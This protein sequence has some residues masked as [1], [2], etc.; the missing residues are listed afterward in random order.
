VPAPDLTVA[1]VGDLTSTGATAVA[2][3]YA[4]GAVRGGD[5]VLAALGIDLAA[6]VEREGWK[7]EAGDVLTLP[8]YG[9][10][11]ATSTVLLVGLGAAADATP[12]TFRK[13]GAALVRK[14]GKAESVYCAVTAAATPR[15]L[16]AFA[17]GALLAAYA[18][19]EQ[20]SDPKPAP[21][22]S[23]VLGVRKPSGKLSAA[24]VRAGQR[25]RATIV[26]RDLA[27]APSLD[28]TPA[29]LAKRAQSL[30]KKAGVD[31]S[32]ME[33]KE[34]AAQGFGGV[35]GVG[36]GSTRPPRL[37][38]LDYTPKGKAR[39]RVLL[40]GKGITFDTGGLSIKPND[41]MAA[42]KTDM[43]GGAVVIAVLSAL[44][45]LGLPVRVT[46][47]VPAAEN[48]PSGTAIRPGDVLRH[49]GGK[50]V[51]VLN[52]DAEGR[53]VLADALAYGIE[54]T[55][56]DYV[57]DLATLTGA[58]GIALGKR[59]AGLFANDDLLAGALLAAAGEAGERM[60]RMPLVEDYRRDL[61]SPVADLKNIG[62]KMGG[63]SITAALFLREFVAGRRWAH[64]DIASSARSDNDEDEI[65]KGATGFGVR[66]LLTW[67]E[68]L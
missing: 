67:L 26:V 18:F 11:G 21:L 29:W 64:L 66:T 48:M 27:N 23:V 22:K 62:G 33:P 44:P 49:Y 35:L 63:G 47:L 61:D 5:K 55:D 4:D 39:A 3:P 16:A 25:A 1:A 9:R 68:S 41:G 56:P 37:I 31:V 2:L 45:A 43:A 6:H 40:V 13:A 19:T 60:W 54:Q 38:R 20:K 59:V 52:T 10:L 12:A 14:A 17:E 24:L 51:E 15:E 65:S 50:T 8:A 28:K 42:M 58:I 46:G 7:G 30:G 32:V 36:A 57:V 53:L 34:L